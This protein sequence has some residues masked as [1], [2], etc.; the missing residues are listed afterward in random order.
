M[1]FFMVFSS[2][3]MYVLV[4]IFFGIHLSLICPAL[5][6][7]HSKDGM[8]GAGLYFAEASSKSDFWW[9]YCPTE[10]W[11]GIEWMS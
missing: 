6:F 2:F 3:V 8:F 11:D 7:V 9:K 10:G 5:M 1:M 4:L